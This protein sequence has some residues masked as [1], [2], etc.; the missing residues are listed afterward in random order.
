MTCTVTMPSEAAAEMHSVTWDDLY[1]A[2][3]QFPVPF[4]VG[5]EKGSFVAE[6]VVRLVPGRRMVVFGFWQG[7]PAVAKL[8]YD[9]NDAARHYE[10]DVTGVEAM[11]EKKIPT[12]ALIS[13][14][15]AHDERIYVL[16]F[17]RILKGE[18][19]EKIWQMREC[20]D[21]VLPTLQAVM[22]ELATQ[23]VLGVMQSDMHMGNFIVNE[24]TIY[25]LDGADITS[26]DMMLS[27]EA[28]M[29]N[30]ALF[31]SQLGAGVNGLQEQLFRHYARARGNNAK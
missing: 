26:Q 13:E 3:Y 22:I 19:L 24:K 16:I 31:L 21:D 1:H 10:K 11:V 18:S 20:I 15:S 23:H 29:K 30:L 25:T 14:G 17:D 2:D 28:S 7:K 9:R 8:F 4:L 6:Q 27:R 5:M 12:A